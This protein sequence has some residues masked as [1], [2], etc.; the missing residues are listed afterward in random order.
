MIT[1]TVFDLLKSR[2]KG[3][4]IVILSKYRTFLK[5]TAF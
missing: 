3:V 2:P 4:E 1:F 5:E